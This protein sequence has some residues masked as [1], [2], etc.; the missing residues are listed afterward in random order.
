MST[1]EEKSTRFL[2]LHSGSSPLLMPNA[3]DAG[4]AVLLASLGFEAIATT[5]SGFAATLGRLDGS[6][7]R[8]EALAHGHALAEA[9]DVPVSADLENGFADEPPRV[10]ETVRAAIGAGLAGCS[11]EDYT[12]RRHE[13]IYDLGLAA[14]RVA[15]AV[16]AAHGGSARL[17]LTAR[18]ENYIRG[19]EDLPDTIARL[20]RYQEV[21][22]DVLF[23]PGLTRIDDVR[24]LVSSLDRPVSFLA[25][26][27]SPPVAELAAVGVRRISVGG[28]FAFVALG[29][30]VE[31]ARE[32][33]D[34]GTY[35]YWGRAA[36]GASAARA[37]F[38]ERGAPA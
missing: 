25:L 8:D 26:A 32:L 20:Q 36:P 23:A 19:R 24:A 4:S 2:E 31:A 21:G 28:A 7:S 38:R 37:A 10:A 22:A 18:A 12:G 16:E 35:G 14:D 34:E 6:V 15:A 33:R 9:T 11:I 5:S 17:V 30:V 3:W 13:A 1:Q 29:A 27:D